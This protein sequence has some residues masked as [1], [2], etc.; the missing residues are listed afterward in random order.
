MEQERRSLPLYQGP[1]I[2]AGAEINRPL[3]MNG[4]H[5]PN[6]MMNNTTPVTGIHTLSHPPPI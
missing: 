4:V 2:P 6:E 5:M 1:R 3:R